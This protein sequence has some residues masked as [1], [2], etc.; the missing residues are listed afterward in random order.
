[1]QAK[2][3]FGSWVFNRTQLDAPVGLL[4]G[5]GLDKPSVAV[6]CSP[7]LYHPRGL[8]PQLRL[9][10]NT[11][12]GGR[13][14]TGGAGVSPAAASAGGLAAGGGGA[15]GAVQSSPGGVEAFH[16]SS[17]GLSDLEH[18]CLIAVLTLNEVGGVDGW[19]QPV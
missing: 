14:S 1:M 7:R 19:T 3:G 2:V 4:G 17:T 12:G 11:G 8:I 15:G 13:A 5:G 18:R 16:E 10:Q 9:L 6:R